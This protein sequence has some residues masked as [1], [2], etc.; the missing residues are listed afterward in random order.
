MS[1]DRTPLVPES[2]RSERL[3]LR[4]WRAHDA[5]ALHPILEA[6]YAH[7]GPWIPARVAKPAP[8]PELEQRLAGFEVAF[9][10][11]REWRY[12]LF[13]AGDEQVVGEVGL[14]PRD[15]HRRRPFGEADRIEVGYW[16][17][18]DVTGRGLATEATRAALAIASALPGL[19]HAEIRCD[20]RN[21]ASAAIPRRLGFTHA[22]T[23]MEAPSA[24]SEEPVA[25]QVWIRKFPRCSGAGS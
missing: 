21:H 14:F 6:N 25:L 2:A 22:A 7:L 18:A 20:A 10:E 19:T 16:L 8:I 3:V 5:A 17:R 9:D 24:P 1:D 23:E 11:T 4:R 15:A 12:G 13:I